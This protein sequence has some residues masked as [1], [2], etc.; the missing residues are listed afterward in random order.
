M[1]RFQIQVWVVILVIAISGRT[2]AIDRANNDK[3]RRK[4]IWKN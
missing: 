1:V 4:E 2:R 3:R